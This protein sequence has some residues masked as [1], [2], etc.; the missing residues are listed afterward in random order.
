M[1]VCAVIPAAGMGSRLGGDIPKILLGVTQNETVWSILRGKLL[2]LVDHIHIVIAPRAEPLLRE[3][4]KADAG[5]VSISIQPKPTG[6]GDAIF[7]GHAQWSQADVILVI[8]GDQVFVSQQTLQA[9]LTLHAG[10]PKT[11]AIPLTFTQ[12]PYVEYLFNAENHLLKINQSREG[13]L[14]ASQ[15]WADV[16]TFLLSTKQLLSAWQQYQQTMT[17][18]KQTA[19]INFLPFLPFLSAQG[20]GVKRIAVNDCRQARGINTKEDLAFFQ[21]LFNTEGIT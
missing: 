19:E 5:R 15:G 9:A 10:T 16:G 18:G 11:I 6:M 13:D 12:N 8:W 20:W 1:K 14:C 21:T 17:Q 7:H 2:P 4:V 3:A